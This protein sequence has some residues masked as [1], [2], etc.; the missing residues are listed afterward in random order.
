MDLKKIVNS[1][2]SVRV[3]Q[4]KPVDLEVIKEIVAIA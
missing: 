1:R 2:H 3:F 4:D